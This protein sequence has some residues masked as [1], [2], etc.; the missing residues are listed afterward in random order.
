[1]CELLLIKVFIVQ[2]RTELKLSFMLL[3]KFLLNYIGET[4]RNFKLLKRI[5]NFKLLFIQVI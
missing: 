5:S 4:L 2:I 3:K 1:M